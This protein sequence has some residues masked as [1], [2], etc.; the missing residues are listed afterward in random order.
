MVELS[1]PKA[2]YLHLELDA[3]ADEGMGMGYIVNAEGLVIAMGSSSELSKSKSISVLLLNAEGLPMAISSSSWTPMSISFSFPLLND[4]FEA[5]AP[6]D[7]VEV[8][9]A[10]IPLTFSDMISYMVL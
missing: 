6:C 7:C 4:G 3:E 1:L 10:C 8:S 9:K 2:V 5:V